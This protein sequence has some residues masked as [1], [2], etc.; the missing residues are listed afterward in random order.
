MVVEEVVVAM[1]LLLLLTLLLI[2]TIESPTADREEHTETSGTAVIIEIKWMTAN[3]VNTLLG[4]TQTG[5]TL[6]TTLPP[7]DT[8][9]FLGWWLHSA[10]SD[11]VSETILAFSAK[12]TML[13]VAVMCAFSWG[14]LRSQMRENANHSETSM[15]LQICTDDLI[16][17]AL[18]NIN[19]CTICSLQIETCTRQCEVEREEW[20]DGAET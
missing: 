16:Y 19:W 5:S 6:T 12:V 10:E 2:K 17:K 14:W 9:H 18:N 20:N 15:L 7:T 8:E 11:W 13:V 1:V 3:K 4:Y